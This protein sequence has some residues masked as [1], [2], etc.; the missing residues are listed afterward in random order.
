MEKYEILY[1]LPAKHTED[2]LKSESEKIKGTLVSNGGEVV[3][4]H[5]M[6]RR[7]LAY[8]I[9]HVRYGHYYLIIFKAEQ[10][11]VEKMNSTLLLMSELLRHLIIKRDPYIIGVPALREE[12][13][14]VMKE[15]ADRDRK[16]RR[17]P[18]TERKPASVAV[19]DGDS[20]KKEEVKEEVV[21]E[22][23]EQTEEEK[24]VTMKDLDE[25]LDKILKDDII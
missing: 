17:R 1:I 7:K 18:A 11:V 15:K 4:E 22:K 6:G 3:E 20:D 9:K 5:Y 2:E 12:E 14:I 21:E 19:K 8:P 10:D 16:P 13:Q 25:K 24:K 23:K